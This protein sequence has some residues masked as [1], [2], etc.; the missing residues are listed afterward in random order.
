MNLPFLLEL[1]HLISTVLRY[2]HSW[3]LGFHTWTGTYVIG[4]PTWFSTLVF[5]RNYPSSFPGPPDCRWQV[6]RHFNL[7]NCIS[8][9]LIINLST[10]GSMYIIWVLCLCRT[11]ANVNIKLYD[12]WRSKAAKQLS[13]LLKSTEPVSGRVNIWTQA[14]WLKTTYNDSSR[15][16]NFWLNFSGIVK[17]RSRLLWYWVL[18]KNALKYDYCW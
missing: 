15:F 8:Q 16:K 14:L 10:F 7:H 11:L 5:H 12:R 17:I 1:G 2:G 4:S 18:H 3:F 13:N 9:S 6:M